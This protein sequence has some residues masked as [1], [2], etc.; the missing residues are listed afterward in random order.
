M[1]TFTTLPSCWVLASNNNGKIA[2]LNDLVKEYNIILKP[3][4]EFNIS[5]IPETGS[6]FI[7]NALLKARHASSIAKCAALADDSGL[8]VADLSGAPGIYSARYAGTQDPKDNITK[9]TTKLKELNFPP[10]HRFAAFFYCIIVLLKFPNDPTPFIAE[11]TWH[12]EV[13]L[14]PRGN[15]G[16]GYDPVFFDS[17]LNCTAAELSASQKHMYSHRGKALSNLLMSLKNLK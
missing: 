3:Q 9:L 6:T 15:N 16:F 17:K 5:E 4:R 2:E 12:G 14:E 7:E 13:I 11:G 1:N 10:E 8:V